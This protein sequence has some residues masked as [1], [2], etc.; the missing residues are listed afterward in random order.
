MSPTE[1][2]TDTEARVIECA[3]N[4]FIEKGYAETSMSDI[5]ARL[6]MKR[7]ALHYYFRTKERMFHAVFGGII[8]AIIPL[9]HRTLTQRHRP[10]SERIS[11]I[12]DAY[13]EVFCRHPQLPLFVMKEIHRDINLLLETAMNR[14]GRHVGHEIVASLLQEMEEGKLKTVPP[15][16][17]LLSFYGALVIP[18]TMRALMESVYLKN[19]ETFEELLAAWKPRII[20]QMKHLLQPEQV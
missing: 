20:S 9:V 13:Y 11:D 17:I 15:R 16:E 7:P 14:V 6:G 5:A 3:R 2:I 18:F 1:T 4:L 8:D 12:I 19:G 10:I